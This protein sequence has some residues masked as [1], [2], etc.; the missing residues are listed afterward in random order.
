VRHAI[1]VCCLTVGCN[2]SS[3]KIV[4]GPP[5]EAKQLKTNKILME[6][7]RLQAVKGPMGP[8]VKVVEASVLF[9]KAGQLLSSKKY[10]AAIKTY[11]QLLQTFPNSRFVSPTLYNVGLCYEWLKDY[12]AAAKRYKE[13]IRRF[14]KTKEAVDAGFR[15]GGCFAELG[16]WDGKI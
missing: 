3:Q 12:G 15:L 5:N 11:D 7:I 4:T 9:E 8:D 2:H 10:P 16:N 13:L 14:G 6:P 1:V